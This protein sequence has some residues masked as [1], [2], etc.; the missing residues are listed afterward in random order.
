[1]ESSALSLILNTHLHPIGTL[2]GGSLDMTQV[3]LA[4][5]AS[6]LAFMATC[7]KG[8]GKAL[9]YEVGSLVIDKATEKALCALDN[10]E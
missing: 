8:L 9:A 7:H 1:M 6:I 3:L 5:R 10:L 4:W 2:L